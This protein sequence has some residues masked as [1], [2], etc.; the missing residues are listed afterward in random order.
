MKKTYRFTLPQNKEVESTNIRVENCEVFVD[1]EFK[2]KFK[3]KDGDFLFV[4]GGVFIYNGKQTDESFGAYI[5]TTRDNKIV[6]SL[7]EDKWSL[8]IGVRY[9]T[10]K[11]KS[12]FLSMVENVFGKRWNLEKKCLENVRWRAVALGEYYSIQPDFTIH[13]FIESFSI[14][15]FKRY[16]SGNYFRDEKYAK[17]IADK[18]REILGDLKPDKEE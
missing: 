9:A 1:V 17:E 12:D 16:A 18:I 8:K 5:G 4:E 3:P 13:R 11:E 10:D 6:Q 15:D 7:T 14:E 2:E